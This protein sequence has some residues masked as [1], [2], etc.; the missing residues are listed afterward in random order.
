MFNFNK[1]VH[2]VAG[3]EEGDEIEVCTNYRYATRHDPSLS[4]KSRAQ[5]KEE[6]KTAAEATPRDVKKAV[7][8]PKV[9]TS[10]KDKK[11]DDK[12]GE[13]VKRSESKVQKVIA[14]PRD[15]YRPKV[16]TKEEKDAWKLY[17]KQVTD[18]YGE[19]VMKQINANESEENP[20]AGGKRIM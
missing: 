6:E 10:K 8:A 2:P 20:I 5:K 18:F 11:T 9:V 7:K 12:V 16:F 1:E 14:D 3:K 4:G 13:V 15:S 19:L 17:T